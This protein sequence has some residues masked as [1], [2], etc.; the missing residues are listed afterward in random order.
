MCINGVLSKKNEDFDIF[1]RLHPLYLTKIGKTNIQSFVSSNKHF[2]LPLFPNLEP[3]ALVINGQSHSEALARS[4]IISIVHSRDQF[5][6]NCATLVIP[7]LRETIVF[8]I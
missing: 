1:Q 2:H 4:T 6:T 8:F 7:I 5:C 3:S